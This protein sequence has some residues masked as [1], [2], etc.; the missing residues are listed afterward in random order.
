M[1]DAHERKGRSTL[2][3]L[4]ILIFLGIASIYSN[5]Q[6]L[7]PSVL[8][9]KSIPRTVAVGNATRHELASEPM[10][11]S[12]FNVSELRL[13]YVHVGKT[14]GVTMNKVLRANC[15]GMPN[16]KNRDYCYSKLCCSDGELLLS[17]HIDKALH[18][19]LQNPRKQAKVQEE[20]SEHDLLW[21]IRH[22][23]HRLVSALDMA[24]NDYSKA[25]N[26]PNYQ[27]IVHRDCGFRAAEDLAEALDFRNATRDPA[28]PK[29]RVIRI[30]NTKNFDCFEFGKQYV[31]GTD[32]TYLS[33]VAMGYQWYSSH[34]PSHY[35][36]RTNMVL[37]TEHLWDDIR[38]TNTLLEESQSN[39]SARNETWVNDL[40]KLSYY[41]YTHGSGAWNIKSNITSR[42]KEILCCYLSNENQIYEDLLLSAIN[43][44]DK[45]KAQSI[46]S[47]YRDCGILPLV[48]GSRINGFDWEK[49]HSEGCPT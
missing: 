1:T 36:N 34:I 26:P 21:S 25:I 47:L 44:S 13:V 29:H 14:A 15:Q 17:Q 12:S 4:G 37:R 9:L 48:S 22:P 32:L 46:E 18:T 39:E 6:V 49:W 10:L 28:F 27:H 8:E 5:S 40:K 23:I 38:Q 43:L 16:K 42:H 3:L 41:K 24:A 35:K 11:P 33:H 30:S 20:Y 7:K 19:F 31:E 2:R 45:Q